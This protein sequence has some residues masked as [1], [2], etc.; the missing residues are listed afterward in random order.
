MCDCSRV[1]PWGVG[2]ALFE[3]SHPPTFASPG[4]LAHSPGWGLLSFIWLKKDTEQFLGL[5]LT[6]E[7][8]IGVPFSRDGWL[9]AVWQG[10]AKPA[11]AR[12]MA[13]VRVGWEQWAQSSLEAISVG[14]VR[15]TD[16]GVDWVGALMMGKLAP[17][18]DAMEISSLPL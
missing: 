1:S 12:G 9:E 15:G 4:P 14:D 11:V 13:L 8:L 3:V 18:R 17:L 7:W 2:S 10:D 16:L 5:G 6:L